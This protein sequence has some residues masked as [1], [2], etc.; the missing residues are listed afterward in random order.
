MFETVIG[1]VTGHVA[2]MIA[3]VL[4]TVAALGAGWKMGRD[5]A[6]K[7]AQGAVLEKTQAAADVAA[8]VNATSD[9]DL[10]K[11]AAKWTR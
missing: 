11:E 4:A 6:I 3:P 2:D 9:D 10:K 1:W 7:A 5:G 8:T